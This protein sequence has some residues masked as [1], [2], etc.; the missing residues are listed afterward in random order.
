[1][2][3]PFVARRRADVSH[4]RP[5]ALARG[6][7]SARV[8]GRTDHQVKVRGYRVELGEIEAALRRHAGVSRDAWWSLR[9]DRPATS[10]WWRTSSGRRATS[11]LREHL[12]ARLPDYM[13]PAAFVGLEALPLTPNGK[14]D[15]KALPAPDYDAGCAPYAPPRT[16]V[17]EVLAEA[18][19][20]VLGLARVSVTD[21][22]FDRGGH[23]LMIMRLSALV[24]A[25]FGVD[26]SIRGV[27][28]APT[29]QSMACEIERKI[30]EQILD[31][32]ESEAERLAAIQNAIGE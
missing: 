17:E 22:F 9:E 7:Q 29:L 31:M 19:M 23:S 15:L 5:R 4:G 30:G 24:R 8:L 32:P 26:L 18:W 1:M 20:E 28:S 11:E 3:D 2:P 25:V 16:P 27:F 14:L 21:N 6:R 12:R 13:V 10:G